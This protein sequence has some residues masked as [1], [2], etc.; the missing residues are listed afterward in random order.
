MANATNEG[1]AARTVSLTARVIAGEGSG[2]QVGGATRAGDPML[3]I[4]RRKADARGGDGQCDFERA[5]QA[6]GPACPGQR[7]R[8]PVREIRRAG[9]RPARARSRARVI[10]KTSFWR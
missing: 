3:T 10:L 2:V 4:D 6:F 7:R 5:E 9:Q 1:Y 8:D